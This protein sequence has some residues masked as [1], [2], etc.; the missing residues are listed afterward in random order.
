MNTFRPLLRRDWLGSGPA[1]L[2]VMLNPST[3]DDTVDDPTL[4]RCIRFAQ[5]EGYSGLRVVNLFDRRATSPSDMVAPLRS[6]N[7]DAGIRTAVAET[8]GPIVCGWGASPV[9]QPAHVAEMVNILRMSDRP[10]ACL[11]TTQSGAPRHPL[12][13]RKRE[14]LAPFMPTGARAGS[15]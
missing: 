4:R 5:R 2:W 15:K 1:Q 10:L 12:Y 13:V 8:L 9:V 6:P 3:A 7:W 11:G 14:P